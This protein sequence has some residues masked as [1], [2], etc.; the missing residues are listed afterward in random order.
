MIG[1]AV[2]IHAEDAAQIL[3]EGAQELF[4]VEHLLQWAPGLT[5]GNGGWK[6]GHARD[7][8]LY[9]TGGL[10][11]HLETAYGPRGGQGIAL[12]I[13]RSAFRCA[14]NH[15]GDS[16][17]FTSVEFR[18]LPAPRRI[19]RGLHVLAGAIADLTGDEITVEAETT[20]WLWKVTS[21]GPAQGQPLSSSCCLIAGL[22][23]GFM[24]WAGGGRFY[25][26]RETECRANGSAACTFLIDSRPV[27]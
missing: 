19:E 23:Q 13:G 4:A 20:G 7:L 8:L 22:L 24:S 21:R 25:Q 18:L 17:G 9:G 15:L 27:D 12:R 10:L 6:N 14:L 2:H 1:P 3:L 5:P 16:A 11:H 26:V